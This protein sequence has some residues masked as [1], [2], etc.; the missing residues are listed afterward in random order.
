MSDMIKI[1]TESGFCCEL[2]KDTLDDMEL[3]EI[4]AGEFPNESFRNAKVAQHLLGD[5]KKNLY[6]HL[7]EIHGKVPATALDRELRDILMAFGDAA[8][9]S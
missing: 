3:V 6:E 2:P 7:R 4:L 1:T 8:K 9:N 5:Q